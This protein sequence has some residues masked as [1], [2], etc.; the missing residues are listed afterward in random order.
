M[1][2]NLVLIKIISLV[3]GKEVD[4]VAYFKVPFFPDEILFITVSLLSF[5]IYKSCISPPTLTG[6]LKESSL[7]LQV[8]DRKTD[9]VD[10]LHLN[11]KS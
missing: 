9:G 8:H 4:I 7:D 3:H 6:N 1:E 2:H 5:F 10:V 11:R